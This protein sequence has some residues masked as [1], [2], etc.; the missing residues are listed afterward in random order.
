[1]KRILAIVLSLVMII[2]IFAGCGA[3]PSP[4]PSPTT[5]GP[6][7]SGP[8]E[9][10]SLK[11]WGSQ[12]D[13]AMLATMVESFKVANPDKDYDIT[14]GVVSEADTKTKVLEDPAAAADVF[15]F[16]SDQI[17][18]LVSAG[19]L[20]EI[21]RNKDKITS[22]NMEGSVDAATVNGKLYAYPETADNGYFMYYDKSVFS[23]EDVKS[24]DKMLD[25]AN[26]KGK[27]VFMD[28]SN[29]WYIASFFLGAGCTLT[30][31]EDGKQK[32]DFNNERGVLAGEAIKEFTAHP[33][34]VTGDDAV[35]KG[36]IGSTIAAGVSGTWN[37]EDI[38]S[39]LGDNYAAT[40]LPTF[41][42][43]DE[44][45]QM[46]SFAGY[47]LVGVNSQTKAP[48]EAMNLAEW[49]TNEQNQILRFET[50]AMGPS[51]IKA[52]NSSAVQENAALAA[53]AEQNQFASSQKDVLGS[54]WAPAEAFG[55]AMEAKDYSKSIKEQ[56]DAMVAQIEG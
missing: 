52:A 14:F 20:Y 8:K 45:V 39:I 33:A 25:V 37:A 35:L 54:F 49:L 50:R 22:E 17:K 43:G 26:S 41:T 2:S 53:L 32:C 38:K 21:T 9:K 13:Q 51:N 29:G 4:S 27:K 46:G 7:T 44:Q 18:D 10:V 11:I 3:L 36:G 55:T 12:E 19:A 42:L 31:S 6:T 24:L 28:V 40:K 1:M 30:I 56:L 16:A 34:F 47:K 5:G 15:A 48:V 23:E